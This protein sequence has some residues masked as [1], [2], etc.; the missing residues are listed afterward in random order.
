M[1]RNWLGR[2]SV[3]AFC[4]IPALA[5]AQAPP[6][7]NADAVTPAPPAQQSL[8]S[9]AGPTLYVAPFDMQSYTGQQPSP[10]LVSQILATALSTVQ[11]RED[12]SFLILPAVDGSDPLDLP[13]F[14][15]LSSLS[16]ADT[17][18]IRRRDG[19]DGIVSAKISGDESAIVMEMKMIDLVQGKLFAGVDMVGSFNSGLL[20]Q[21]ERQVT[22]FLGYL[23]SLYQG[24]ILVHTSPEGALVSLNGEVVGVTPLPVLTVQPGVHDLVITKEGFRDVSRT[25]EVG[26]FERYDM[27][28]TLDPI[29][30]V[31]SQLVI[32]SSPVGAQIE[33]D[34]QT[35]GVTPL[36]VQVTQGDYDLRVSLEGF[37]DKVQAITVQSNRT[38]HLDLDLVSETGKIFNAEG[39]AF[40]IDSLRSQIGYSIGFFPGTLT[41]GFAHH[42][43]DA[44]VSM[45]LW[46][47]LDVGLFF[48]GGSSAARQ[49]IGDGVFLPFSDQYTQYQAVKGGLELRFMPLQWPRMAELHVGGRVGLVRHSRYDVNQTVYLPQAENYLYTVGLD[50]F[51]GG[52]LFL[53]RVKQADL[54]FGLTLDAGVTWT[55]PITFEEKQIN[56]FGPPNY[57]E[58]D[59]QPLFEVY[60]RLSLTLLGGLVE[61]GR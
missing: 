15:G 60:A 16:R 49:S 38:Y 21:V 26:D 17:L 2:F 53:F 55:P 36:E 44:A 29:E 28:V 31:T 4:L 14:D 13:S 48:R 11:R 32:T 42:A 51:I 58:T 18:L 37:A 47:W 57:V 61:A 30:A 9:K 22:R 56:I 25:L 54:S 19:I 40:Y 41:T 43:L 24:V 6:Q 3:F 33:L 7:E 34:G 5:I 27:S 1:I 52:T 23:G 39:N 35:L 59:P 46:R 10:E 20:A 12:N 45:R 8:P 50:G